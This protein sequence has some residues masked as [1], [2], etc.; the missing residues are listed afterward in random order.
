MKDFEDKLND[1][2]E[3]PSDIAIAK[4]PL[5]RKV[6][7]SDENDLDNDYKYAREN[8]YNIIERGQDAIDELLQDARDSGNARMYEVVG[9]LIKTVGEQNKDLVNLH[10]QVKDITNEQKASP[11]NVTNALFVGSTAELQKMLKDKKE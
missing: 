2:L 7:N 3:L 5:E 6:V 9:Q 4:E 1:L 8:M 10:K 11:N